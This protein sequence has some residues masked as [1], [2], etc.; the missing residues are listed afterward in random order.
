VRER[1]RERE[2]EERVTGPQVVVKA[3]KCAQMNASATQ[4]VK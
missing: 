1:E 4:K 3:A 2:R